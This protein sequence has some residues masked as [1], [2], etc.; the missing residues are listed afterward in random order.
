MAAVVRGRVDLGSGSREG[1]EGWS[2]VLGRP[3]LKPIV[4]HSDDLHG[5]VAELLADAA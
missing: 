3:N 5:L 1:K 4:E 2:L